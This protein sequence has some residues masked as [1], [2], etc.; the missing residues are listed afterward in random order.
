MPGGGRAAQFGQRNAVGGELLQQRHALGALL[1]LEPVEQALRGEV[2]RLRPPSTARAWHPD[3]HTQAGVRWRAQ[4]HWT[5]IVLGIDP[6]LA[7]TGYGVV[8]RAAAGGCVA[9]DGGVIETRAR[10]CARAAP[11]RDPRRAWTALLERARA[12]RD[13]ARGALLRPERAHRLRRRPGARRGDAG[14]RPA[15]RCRAS[16][17]PPSRSRARSA[18]AG[19]RRKDQVARMVGALLG[20]RR[21]AATRP[22]GRRARGG[23]LPRQPRAAG[24]RARGGRRG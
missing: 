6:G 19:A 22:R 5:V 17:T 12:R 4:N 11:G 3:G 8:A 10:A 18:A 7:N 1:A 13:R 20:L 21:A 9:L 14:R 15:R 24:A 23:D 2:D 16:A